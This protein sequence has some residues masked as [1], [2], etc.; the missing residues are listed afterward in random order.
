MGARVGTQQVSGRI[1]GPQ[2][3]YSRGR[4]PSSLGPLATVTEPPQTLRIKAELGTGIP[5]LLK[6]VRCKGPQGTGAQ[7][8]PTHPTALQLQPRGGPGLRLQGIAHHL[9]VT[10][11]EAF[12]ALWGEAQPTLVTREA[13]RLTWTRSQGQACAWG[14]SQGRAEAYPR[15]AAVEDTRQEVSSTHRY[16][17]L[18]TPGHVWERFNNSAP[19]NVS[20]QLTT[21]YQV[22]SGRCAR[23]HELTLQRCVRTG[24]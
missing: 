17:P 20:D 23:H 22:P 3:G 14:T 12:G 1:P 19:C 2:M 11:Q 4:L 9:L 13:L 21:E 24:G 18:Q 15:A 7:H 16:A 8:K 5:S 10:L 6:D